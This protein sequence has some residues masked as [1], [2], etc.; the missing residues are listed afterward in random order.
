MTDRRT[1]QPPDSRPDRQPATQADDLE[2]LSAYL[3]DA[4]PARERGVLEARLAADAALQ[5]EL[6]GLR[7]T[8]SVLRTAPQLVPPRS[9]TLDPAQFRR[10][11]PWWARYQR[12]ELLGLLGTAAAVLLI[13]LGLLAPIQNSSVPGAVTPS[14]PAVAM[15]ATEQ[16]AATAESRQAF[17]ATSTVVQTATAV[18]EFAVSAPS[19]SEAVN[20]DASGALTFTPVVGMIAPAQLQTATAPASKMLVATATMFAAELAASDVVGTAPANATLDEAVAAGA[21]NGGQPSDQPLRTMVAPATMQIMVGGAT[22]NMPGPPVLAVT[23][24]AFSTPTQTTPTQRPLLTATVLLT[25]TPPPTLTVAA[26]QVAA[27]PTV[28]PSTVRDLAPPPSP[29][30][31]TLILGV[32]LLVFSVMLWGLGRLRGRVR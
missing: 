23:A 11:L 24:A 12:M 9:F 10:P 31:L 6:R 17:A 7:E 16:E 19:T 27:A 13:A 5:A 26:T 18:L 2:L 4:L 28:P 3:D 1:P 21:A 30:P 32:A 20:A 29:P 25:A 14:N 15:Q 22:A 8:V